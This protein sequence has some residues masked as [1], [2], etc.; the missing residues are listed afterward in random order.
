MADPW[1]DPT[2][3]AFLVAERK[4]GLTHRRQKRF[5]RIGEIPFTSERKMMYHRA[6]P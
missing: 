1:I 2:E 3:A 4:M 6:R 5:E